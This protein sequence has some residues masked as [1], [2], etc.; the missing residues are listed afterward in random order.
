MSH[1]RSVVQRIWRRKDPISRSEGEAD[2]AAEEEGG[3]AMAACVCGG[4]SCIASLN[5]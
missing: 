4:H 3:R 2:A 5:W 1:P